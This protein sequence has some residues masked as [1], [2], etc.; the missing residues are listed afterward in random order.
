MERGRNMSKKCL[1]L[2]A[3]VVLFLFAMGS[4]WACPIPEFVTRTV[5]VE[6]VQAEFDVYRPGQPSQNLGVEY[7]G[8]WP[9]YA[10]DL[11]YTWNWGDGTANSTG[12]DVTHTYTTPGVYIVTVT[13]SDEGIYIDDTD[14]VKQFYVRVDY[15]N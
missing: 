4:V 8:S 9:S 15:S 11:T 14:L 10:E 3:V 6:D 5:L 13:A 12:T 1:V 7:D 2:L